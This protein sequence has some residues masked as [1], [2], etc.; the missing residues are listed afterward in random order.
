LED[1]SVT[2]VFLGYQYAPNIAGNLRFRFANTAKNERFDETVPDSLVAIDDQTLAFFLTPFEYTFFNSPS[3]QLK[4]GGGVYYEY[5]TLTEKGF[6]NMPALESLGKERV[7]S[8]SYDRS[9]H[10]VGPNVTLGFSWRTER[11]GLTVEGGVTPIFY[12]NASQAMSIAPLMDPDR[13]E[14][15]QTTY[16]SPYFY[17]DVSLTLFK[18]VSLALLYDY[19]RLDYRVVD[20]DNELKWWTPEREMV[21]QSLKLEASALIPLGRSVYAQIGYGRTFDS[22]QVSSAPLVESGRDYLI[23]TVRKITDNR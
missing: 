5:Y 7:N 6:F 12:L 10:S 23:F 1:G 21:S 3:V 16:G 9:T 19:S 4:V 15:S 2:D 17:A 11:F 18:Y 20:F 22:L 13:A 14:Y 8:F